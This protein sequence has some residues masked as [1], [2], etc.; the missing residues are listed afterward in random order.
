MTNHL[1]QLFLEITIDN[2][3]HQSSKKVGAKE[4]RE[5]ISLKIKQKDVYKG[6]KPCKLSMFPS[7]GGIIP[8]RLFT[9]R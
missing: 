4:K 7:S 5:T 2:S 1:I 6:N 9:L 8:E 3:S